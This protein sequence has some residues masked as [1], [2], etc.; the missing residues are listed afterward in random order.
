MTP[1]QQAEIQSIRERVENAVS[2]QVLLA[3][4]TVHDSDANQYGFP[5]HSPLDDLRSLVAIVEEQARKLEGITN[6]FKSAQVLL[7]DSQK[8]RDRWYERFAKLETERASCC[9]DNE[10]KA[11]LLA[12]ALKVC[13]P[14]LA[15]VIERLKDVDRNGIATFTIA[16]AERA[17]NSAPVRLAS[18]RVGV[19]G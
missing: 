1:T 7:A 2:A 16:E 15:M 8:D 12:A 18:E 6:G 11:K 17:L 14:A 19:E 4:Y 10:K 5:T 9:W 13:V 3:Q